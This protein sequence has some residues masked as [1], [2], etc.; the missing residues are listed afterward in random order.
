MEAVFRHLSTTLCPKMSMEYI[1]FL[2]K[3]TAF[4]VSCNK[5]PNSY[6]YALYSPQI[7]LLIRIHAVKPAR[8]ENRRTCIVN[9]LI[10]LR[11]GGGWLVSAVSGT[12]YRIYLEYG[13]KL[14]AAFKE[15]KCSQIKRKTVCM[16][17]R[18]TPGSFSILVQ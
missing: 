4:E 11:G 12:L 6:M 14:C 16:P 8:S 1:F 10:S 7:G 9:T 15:H 5:F 17:Q 2:N 18:V 3:L 13:R